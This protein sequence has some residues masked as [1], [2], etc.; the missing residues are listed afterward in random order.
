MTKISDAFAAAM[1]VY[2]AGIAASD[3]PIAKTFVAGGKLVLD[4]AFHQPK[5][6]QNIADCIADSLRWSVSDN[7][8]P[9][10]AARNRIL[11]DALRT[12]LET[13]RAA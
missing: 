8:N 10:I 3:L 7:G 6:P 4:R 13:L 5:G 9:G 11:D 2:I 1:T 12:G